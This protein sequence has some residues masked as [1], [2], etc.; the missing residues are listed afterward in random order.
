MPFTA[1]VALAFDWSSE[2]QSV[3]LGGALQG[4]PAKLIFLSL[5]AHPFP[6]IRM[7]F[8]W[9][10]T[11]AAPLLLGQATFFDEFDVCFFRRRGLFQIDLAQGP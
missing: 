10:A 3:T 8:A 6:P 11:D 5:A 1:G 9:L 7:P 2:P 4:I